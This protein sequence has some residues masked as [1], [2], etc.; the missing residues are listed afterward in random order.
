[1]YTYTWIYDTGIMT[2]NRSIHVK[3][4]ACSYVCICGTN[5]Q[6]TSEEF[7]CL[8]MTIQCLED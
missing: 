8:Q 5:L 2:P 4:Y 6:S 1:M 7:T 3:E